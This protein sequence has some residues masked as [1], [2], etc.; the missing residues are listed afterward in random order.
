ML[1]LGIIF[2][3][4]SES[5]PKEVNKF[6]LS[7][8]SKKYETLMQ[9]SVIKALLTKNWSKIHHSK[10]GHMGAQMKCFD[11]TNS[12]VHSIFLKGDRI[13]KRNVYEKRPNN[14]NEQFL[15]HSIFMNKQFYLIYWKKLFEP[16]PNKCFLIFFFKKSIGEQTVF[17][18]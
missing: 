6:Y 4:P 7:R 15:G 12:V 2:N 8:Y 5:P 13:P 10:Y 11:E 3:F 14:I 16:L 1:T 17:T 18:N 9:N